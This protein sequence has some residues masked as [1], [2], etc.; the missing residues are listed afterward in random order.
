MINNGLREVTGVYNSAGLCYFFGPNPLIHRSN[1]DSHYV[2]TMWY[3]G[4]L[5]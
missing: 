3:N 1:T 5:Q 2:K 4:F